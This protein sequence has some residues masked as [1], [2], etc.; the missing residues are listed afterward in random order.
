V[1]VCTLFGAHVKIHPAFLALAGLLWWCGLRVELL[2]A[3]AALG[4]HEAA[5]LAVARLCGLDVEEIE[6]LPF[7][8]VIRIPSGPRSL[9]AEGA[10]AMAGPLFSFFLQRRPLR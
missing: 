7:G 9:P 1:T 8:G 2:L 6:V 5:H 3:L 4:G 10:M